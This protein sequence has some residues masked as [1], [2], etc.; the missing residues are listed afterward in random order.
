M[1][2]DQKKFFVIFKKI[3]RLL[4]VSNFPELHTKE[5][6]KFIFRYFFT[7]CLNV[8]FM[9]NKCLKTSRKC[10]RKIFEMKDC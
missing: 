1:Y 9:L 10:S 7:G 3:F 6:Y 5:Q 4:L 8:M 2:L